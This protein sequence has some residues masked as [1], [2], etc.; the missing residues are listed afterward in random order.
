MGVEEAEPAAGGHVRG[1]VRPPRQHDADAEGV[2][3]EVC[4]GLVA[5]EAPHAV[6][7]NGHLALAG[8]H[9][10]DHREEVDI[11]KKGARWNAGRSAH[12][13]APSVGNQDAWEERAS[14]TRVIPH[15][16]STGS[17]HW[18]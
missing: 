12:R 3:H 13:V 15:P 1:D 18:W 4:R 9:P 6:E 10:T 7:V 2:H 11:A 14:G 8:R 16:S 5:A 17:R